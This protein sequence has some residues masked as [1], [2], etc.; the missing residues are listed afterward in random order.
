MLTREHG[1][2]PPRA[3]AF[4]QRAIREAIRAGA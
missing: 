1:L 3:R 2:T 4:E